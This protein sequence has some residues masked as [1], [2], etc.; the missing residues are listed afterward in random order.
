LIRWSPSAAARPS[1][2]KECHQPPTLDNPFFWGFYP[3]CCRHQ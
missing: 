1:F 3:Y 2:I